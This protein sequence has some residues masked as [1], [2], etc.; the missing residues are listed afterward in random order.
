MVGE[1]N[2]FETEGTEQE[3]NM[4]LIHIHP[5]YNPLTNE[6]DIAL[7][8]LE[9]KV[10]LNDKV[11]TVCLPSNKTNFQPGTVCSTGGWGT[12]RYLGRPSKPLVLARVPLVS[13]E[14]CNSTVAYRGSIK[15]D[16]V[17]AGNSDGGLD[18]CQGDGGGPL[19]CEIRPGKH[20]LV[21]ISSW[22]NG[23]ASPN[24]YGVY[25]DVRKHLNWIESI[26]A[27]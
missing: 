25:T 7:I 3:H 9:G 11:N 4:K 24:K 12:T 6:N 18:T 20:I 27:L 23:C 21:G 14:V 13:S 26:L 8:N 15:E 22:G 17:C 10:T 1:L 16:M 5:N 19:T 2:L